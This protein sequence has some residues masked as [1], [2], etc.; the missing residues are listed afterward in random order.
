MSGVALDPKTSPVF[1][2]AAK[3]ALGDTQM[4]KNVRHATNVIQTKRGRVVGEMPDWQQ[5][6]EAGKQ[7]RQH[8]MEHLDFYLEQFEEN[9]TRVGGVVHWARDAEEAKRIVTGL[10]KASG[11]DEVIKIKSMT[12]EEIHLNDALEAAGIHAYETDLAELIIQLGQDQPSHIVVPALHKNRQQIRE[13][14]QRKMNLPELGESPQDLADAARMFLREKFLRV[15]TG[16]SGANFLI[17]ETGGVCIVESEGNGRMCLTLPETLITIAGID[18]VL[19][20]FQDLEVVL[21]LLPRSATGERM[22]P[23]NSIWTGVKEGDGPRAFHVVLMD[24]ARTEILADKEG[25]QTLNCIRCGACQNV[26]P[27]Y[28]QTGGQAYGSVYAGPIGAIL[29]PQLQEMHHAQSL[30]YASSLCGACYEVCPVKINIPEVLIHLRNKVVKQNTAGIVGLFDVEAGAMKAMAMIFK[31][32]R[33]F[34]AAQR[35]GRMAETPLVRKDGRGVGWIG[36][37]P[38]MLGGWTQVRDLQEMPKE[39]FRDWWEKRRTNGN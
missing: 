33:R 39:T 7:I 11:S 16:V 15:K 13:I 25:R 35:L 3:A 2:M 34:R 31:S 5:L 28:R 4:R 1:P 26:C 22:N 6:R 14:F 20:R 18:K 19:P 36:W 29:T 38:G 9:C 8:T 23:Y 12:T 21:Q 27:V 32:E 24:N 10:V 37:L 30:P 17:A